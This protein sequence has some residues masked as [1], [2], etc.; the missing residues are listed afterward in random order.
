M[1]LKRGNKSGQLT[2]FIIIAILIIAIALWF[3]LFRGNFGSDVPRQFEPIYNNFITCLEEDIELGTSVLETQGGYIELPEYHAG[4]IA[5]PFSSRL[6]FVGT[7]IPYWYYISGG[8]IQKTQVPNIENMQLELENFILSRIGACDFEWYYEQGY[9]LIFGEGEPKITIKDHEITLDLDMSFVSRYGEDGISVEDHKISI[10]SDL[11]V[12]YK[13]ALKVYGHE[14]QEFFLEKYGLDILNLYAPVDGVEFTCSPKI[15]I[16]DNVFNDLEEAIEINTMALYAS[17]EEE[18]FA[19]DIETGNDVQFMNSRNW[20]RSFEVNPTEGNVMIANPIGNQPGLGILGFC[21]VTYHF[22]YNMNYPVLVQV[23]STDTGEVFQFPL[24]VVIEGNHEREPLLGSAVG[25]EEIELCKDLNTPVRVE[26]YDILTGDPVEAKISYNCFNQKCNIGE[27]A[28]GSLTDYFPQCV[29]G[30][31]LVNAEGYEQASLM[32]STVNPGQVGIFLD[33]LYPVDVNLMVE[34]RPYSGS[35]IINF[36]SDDVSKTV[37]YPL[38][39]EVELSEGDY[40][41]SVYVY[42]D[43]SLKLPES[44]IEQCV[45]V[46]RGIL[47]GSLGLTKEECFDVE[48]PE[49]LIT[50]ALIAGG[51]EEYSIYSSYLRSANSIELNV[52]SL[53]NPESIQQIQENYILFEEKGVDI[54]FR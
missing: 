43:S 35:A 46:P 22:V 38:Q 31:I 37:S 39:K 25:V 17:D 48:Y 1:V 5:F 28:G 24:A 47:L 15:W 42:G 29:N 33:K 53:P 51:K 13:D 9:S 11:G 8:G 21:Y 20:P 16:A 12:L 18:Y 32:H 41:V 36:I 2:I 23:S 54:N 49:Q 7:E 52:E 3:F 26:V 19:V 34:G 10:D 6:N 50:T 45:E 14:Q 44:T 40:E 4:T 30:F 27:T